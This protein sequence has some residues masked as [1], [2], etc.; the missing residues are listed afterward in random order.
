M[1]VG[2]KLEEARNRKGISIREA[3]ES[4][5]IRGDYL[6]AFESSSFD[7]N[8][9]EVYL[10]GFVRLYARFLDLD[11]DAILADLAIEMGNNSGKSPRKSLGSIK[12]LE[13]S[14]NVDLVNPTSSTSSANRKNLNSAL[15]KPII[16]TFLSLF[17]VIL[18]I[19]GLIYGLS[20]NEDANDKVNTKSETIQEVSQSQLSPSENNK[21]SE[22]LIYNLKLKSVGTID[23]LIIDDGKNSLQEFKNIEQG[24][25]KKIDILGSFRCYCSD[26]ENLTFS[27]N[28]KEKK[29]DGEG[30][31]HFSWKPDL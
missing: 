4:T 6:S 14:E 8:L 11:Q 28:G 18:V 22:P 5:K 1:A 20:G 25:E 13:G 21:I 26:L 12:S 29:A 3:E 27:I 30:A 24:W 19:I 17:L 10:R 9:P 16:F 7:I 2:Q 31:G 15:I 23:M